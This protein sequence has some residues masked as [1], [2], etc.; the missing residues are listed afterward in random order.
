MAFL[1]T[2]HDPYHI[3]AILGLF[4]LLSF[5][6]R[7][8]NIVVF[9]TAFPETESK[10]FTYCSILSHGLLPIS[11]LLL[12]IPSKRNFSSPMIWPEF[13]LHNIVFGLRH[14]IATFME[15]TD[16][17]PKSL[18]L[19]IV[20]KTCLIITVVLVAKLISKRYGDTNLRTT[21]AMPYPPSISEE[22]QQGVK[23]NYR[24]AQFYA[25]VH[26]V[27]G[28][29]TYA[30]IPLLGIQTAPFLMTL[31]RKNIISA[32]W[33]HRIYSLTLYIPYMILLTRMIHG[34]QPTVA[35]L[36]VGIFVPLVMDPLRVKLS[37]SPIIVWLLTLPICLYIVNILKLVEISHS[38]ELIFVFCYVLYSPFGSVL[39]NYKVLFLPTN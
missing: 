31:V 14:V 17:W 8:I 13:R 4:V 19:S 3:H 36:F 7:I 37:L 9:G 2:H 1:F 38:F 39:G 25:T 35:I 6:T 33:Y 15:V 18:C 32:I 10:L 5:L 12:P 28:D 21:N 24:I 29:A 11:S 20:C 22:K 30:Y 27:I 16:S 23:Y 34:S 26:S